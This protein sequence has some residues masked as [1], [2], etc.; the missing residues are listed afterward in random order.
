MLTFCVRCIV[1][2]CTCWII[3]C[4]PMCG[5]LPYHCMYPRREHL[6]IHNFTVHSIQ[7]NSL[8]LQLTQVKESSRVQ[9]QELVNQC[10]CNTVLVSF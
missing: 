6:Y 8:Q 5:V 10:E 4:D 2:Y 3:A 1:D 7:I 9:N